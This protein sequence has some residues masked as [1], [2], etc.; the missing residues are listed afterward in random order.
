MSKQDTLTQI[1]EPV[2]NGVGCELWGVEYT[3]FGKSALLRIYIDKEE[4]VTLEDCSE[5][6]YQVSGI[7]D[8]E[9]PITVAYTLEVSSPGLDRPLLSPEH[10]RRY[11]GRKIAVNCRWPVKGRRKFNGI[12]VSVDEEGFSLDEGGEN[13]RISYDSVV[14]AKLTDALEF[15][16]GSPVQ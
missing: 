5:V 16:D 9:E 12:I 3:P 11:T 15:E 13:V 1:I 4:G 7:L 14:K 6:S 10:Y 2:V 8:V